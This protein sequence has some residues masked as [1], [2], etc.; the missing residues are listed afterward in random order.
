MD[1]EIQ[2]HGKIGHFGLSGMKTHARRINAVLMIQSI[3]GAGTRVLVETP[4]RFTKHAW[5]KVI[6]QRDRDS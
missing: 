3:P 6:A 4:I 2:T 5:R 1:E